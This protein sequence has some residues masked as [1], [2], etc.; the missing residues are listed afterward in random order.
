MPKYYICINE[1]VCCRLLFFRAVSMNARSVQPGT[2]VL[3]EV[4]RP[5]SAPL[6]LTVALV[7]LYVRKSLRAIIALLLLPLLTHSA[8]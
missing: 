2:T 4:Q 3:L 6:V 5:M 8:P 1:R 7:R